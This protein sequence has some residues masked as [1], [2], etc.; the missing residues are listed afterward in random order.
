MCQC[1]GFPWPDMRDQ[2]AQL[3]PTRAPVSLLS[4]GTGSLAIALTSSQ[5][6]DSQQDTL[7]G[8]CSIGSS[9]ENW[10]PITLG[11]S[12]ALENCHREAAK[13]LKAGFCSS[14]HTRC[15]S[16]MSKAECSFLPEVPSIQVLSLNLI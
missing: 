6:Q 13:A 10:S 14:R 5:K 9:S 1:L 12:S 4:V 8:V 16:K 15:T 2:L 11:L 7:S 3:P